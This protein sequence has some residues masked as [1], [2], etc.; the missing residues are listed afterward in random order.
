[1]TYWII[2]ITLMGFFSYLSFRF[3]RGDFHDWVFWTGLVLK[4]VAG[5]ILGLMFIYHFGS[6]DTITFF[7]LAKEGTE[8]YNQPRTQF[9]VTLIRPIVLLSGGSYWITSLWISFISFVACWNALISL[10]RLYPKIKRLLAVCFLFIPSVVFWSSGVMKDALTFAALLTVIAVSLSLH[11]QA[12]LS[13]RDILL[14]LIGAF[15]LFKIK[16]YLLIS[17]LIFFSILLS[18][19]ALKKMQGRTRWI[20]AIICL[21]VI[22][23]ST[24]F[25]HPYLKVNRIAW[26]LY[27]NNHA[28]N[29][30][31]DTMQLN[32][33][34]EDDSWISVIREVPNALH[35]GLFRPSILDKTPIWGWIHKV[36]NLLLTTLMFLSLLLYIKLKPKM[37]WPLLIA[38]T[39]CILLLATMLP[40]STPNFGTLVRYKNAFMPFLFLMSSIL[41]YQ[42]FNAKSIE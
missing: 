38:A 41:P 17:T 32:I 16:H 13:L 27:E 29:Q 18:N 26:A 14:F 21:L 6:G 8:I 42:Y 2:H 1:M 24:Q 36:E 10:S 37:D 15:L 4:L 35:A 22:W 7:E 11:N 9:F 25:I 5:I 31:S 23:G 40:L 39:I 12:K 19:L 20:V 33:I 30:Q 34:I 3:L 28:I